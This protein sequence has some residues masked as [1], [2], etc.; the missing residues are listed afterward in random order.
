MKNKIEIYQTEDKQME[1]SVNFENETVWLSQLQLAKLF[2][3]TKQTISLHINNCYKEREL[4]RKAT[5]RKS[6]TVQK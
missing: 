1:L 6:L 2:S 4:K 5:V 3:Q